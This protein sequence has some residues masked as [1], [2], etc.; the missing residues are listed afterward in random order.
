MS[1]ILVAY[2]SAT[3]V[4][5]RCAKTLADSISGDLFEIMPVVPYT[6]CDL[7][8]RNP[9]SRSSYEMQDIF[10]RPQI[11][12]RVEEMS[13]YNIVFIGFPIWWYVAPT[14]VNTFLEQ[15]NFADT[16]IVPFATS[17]SSGMEKV[18]E[19]LSPSCPDAKLM[20]GTIFSAD[21][22]AEECAKW[23]DQFIKK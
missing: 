6:E 10:S 17:G 13:K 23:A 3:G 8:W 11:A 20:E 4:T 1:N 22:T 2:F 15:Y 12:G 5:E 9:K 21:I 14:I 19:R 16:L 7:N 18:N